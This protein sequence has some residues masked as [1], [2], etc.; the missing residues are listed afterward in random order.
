MLLSVVV[1][2]I[3]ASVEILATGL[4]YTSSQF[5]FLSLVLLLFFLSLLY[6]SCTYTPTYK[7]IIYHSRVSLG[8]T[9]TICVS[10]TNFS[11][12][13]CGCWCCCRR[14]SRL[15]YLGIALLWH[16]IL[17]SSVVVNSCRG[18]L[19]IITCETR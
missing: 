11:C 3:V 2:V 4:F 10:T 1:V 5:N 16:S 12:R 13:R 14:R 15:L 9:K 6:F 19:L 8:K 17:L 18:T 7:K